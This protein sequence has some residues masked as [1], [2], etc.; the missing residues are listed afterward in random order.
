MRKKA[1]SWILVMVMLLSLVTVLP[2]TASAEESYDAEINVVDG[3]GTGTGWTFASG[4][5]WINEGGSYLI[6]GSGI[7][8][9]NRVRVK[10]GV[11]ASVTLDNVNI[12]VNLPFEVGGN[13]NVTMI[14]KDGSANVFRSW[15]GHAGIRVQPA[16][17]L[18]ITA[19]GQSLSDGAL[20]AYGDADGSSHWA[21]AG[22]GGSEQEPSGTIVIDGG[23]IFAKGGNG[24]P[25]GTWTGPGAAGI[26]GAMG[27]ACG[28]IT[29]NGGTV[30]A[31]GGDVRPEGAGIGGGSSDPS[32]YGGKI[33]INGGT[34]R[35]YSGQA[36]ESGTGIGFCAS[37]AIA[38]TADVQAYSSGNYPAI[39]GITSESGHSVYLQNFMLDARVP[40]DTDMVITQ[41][42]HSAE[43]FEMTLLAN[44][45]N[46]ATTVGTS[47]DY[48]ASLSDGSKIIVSLLDESTAFPGILDSPGTALSSVSVKLLE[49]DTVAP[50]LTAGPVYRTSATEATVRFVSDTAGTYYYQV[51]N[52]STSPTVDDLSGW[53]S[54]GSVSADTITAVS[55]VGLTTGAK[56]VHIVVEDAAENLSDTLTVSMPYDIYFFD[57]FEAYPENTTASSGLLSFTQAHNGNGNSNQ[58]VVTE[59]T[60]QVFSL[61]GQSNWASDQYIA[62]PNNLTGIIVLEAKIKPVSGTDP[63]YLRLFNGSQD[64]AT[65]LVRDGYWHS[66]AAGTNTSLGV[67]YTTD[68]WYAV[69]LA[70]DTAAN[71]FDI[72]I[73]G[74]K[75]N[76]APITGSLSTNYNLYLTAGNGSAT[77]AC[78][79]DVRLYVTSTL[80]SDT[81]APVLTAGSVSR[82]TD[83]SATVK[84]TSD[85]AGEYY[86]QVVASGDSAPDIDTT[87][88]G[89]PCG[90]TEQT[91]S[92]TALTAGAKD[93]YI[94]VKDA[95]GNVSSSNFKISIPAYVPAAHGSIQF[96][97]GNWSVPEDYSGYGY[98][99]RVGGSDGIVTVDYY[100]VDDTAVAGTDYA[101]QSGT[102]TWADGN[103]DPKTIPCTIYNDSTYNGYLQFSYVL[104][105][106]T[107]GAVLGSQDTLLMQIRDNDNPPIPLG[108]TA[109][110]GNGK[111]TLNWNEV[112]DAYYRVYFSTTSASY[113]EADSVDVYDETST[114]ITGLKNGTKYYFVVK[115]VHDIYLSPGSNEV[116]ATPT[117]G[118]GGGSSISPD[119]GSQITVSTTDDST[120]VT[121]TLTRVNGGTQIDIKNRAFD[122]LD[123]ADKPVSINARIATVTFDKKAMDAIGEKSGDGDVTITA[124]QVPA[125]ELSRGD[126]ALVGS[127]SVYDFTVTSGGKTISD[128]N[129]GYATVSIPYTLLPG[130]N[131]HA[132]IIWYLSD[133]GTLESMRGCYDTAT[134]T[135]TFVTPHFSYFVIGYNLVAFSDVTAGAWYYD[136]VTFLAARGVTTGTTAAAFSPD[137]T[138]TRGQ[139][140]VM[141]L[142]A[143]GIEAD[144]I[145]AD[146]FFDAGNTYYTGYLA[147]AKRLGITNGVGNNMFAPDTAITRQEMFTLLYNALRAIGGQ[148]ATASGKTLTDF[149]DAS[150]IA[151]WA[152]DAMMLLV[153]SGTIS[154]SGGKLNPTGITTRGEMAQVLYNLLHGQKS[155]QQ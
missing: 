138:L 48:T 116:S 70:Y 82:T 83:T 57:A 119:T 69:R 153:E 125:S 43:T 63:A 93:I 53:T 32:T 94:V 15:G 5:I 148:P 68:T 17:T 122:K 128:F 36:G 105:S 29:I 115:A 154:G 109:T 33:T 54:G 121:G 92:L 65:V 91:I 108:L 8:T 74:V 124:R 135:V 132:V 117:S 59:G 47:N 113:N 107:G 102:L 40:F 103:S 86:Y 14:L 88:D 114:V 130:E 118:N 96:E 147:A 142:R 78:F 101:A 87:G 44:Y 9:A 136:A 25:A 97:S 3:T 62:L 23:T 60:N 58:K 75:A 30:T 152:K 110:A 99:E 89:T 66:R 112:K 38:D 85:E 81:T 35:A 39:Y 77:T 56:Y 12:N 133:S 10:T 150:T 139:F 129:G 49:N 123:A 42:D 72:W 98:V 104:S 16:A 120:S 106:P 151:P 131:P 50:I 145:A 64:T 20:S 67:A 100:T 144:D 141:L 31:I 79:D 11:T 149:S 134:K 18:T 24:R 155:I 7:Q 73:D 95:A 84:F 140:I 41:I 28:D 80:D 52:S 143:Y 55:P 46:F 137:A 37:I 71:T 26:G 51:T 45:K 13:S 76:T 1:L 111:V 146:N 127:R 4:E 126:R 27:Q 34:I 90:T 2:I 6:S 61:S 21:S 19:A 22:I